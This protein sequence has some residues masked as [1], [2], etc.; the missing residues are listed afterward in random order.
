MSQKTEKLPYFTSIAEIAR[1]GGQCSETAARKLEKSGIL[2]IAIYT[3]G[4]KRIPL[5]SKTDMPAL[6]QIIGAQE[7]V[8]ELNPTPHAED[9]P[10][11]MFVPHPASAIAVVD[12][13]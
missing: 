5:Y 3:S 1:R 6:L 12:L 8:N 4:N 2:P 10:F 13:E 11:E 7:P 9:Q